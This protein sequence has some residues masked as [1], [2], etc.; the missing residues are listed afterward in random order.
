MKAQQFGD[1]YWT[2]RFAPYVLA[3]AVV[4][5]VT[6]LF[7]IRLPFSYFPVAVLSGTLV[8]FFHVLRWRTSREVFQL[9]AM[10]SGFVPLFVVISQLHGA[11]AFQYLAVFVLSYTAAVV[12]FRRQVFRGLNH[13]G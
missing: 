1:A 13:D 3:A 12:I 9:A 6:S 8:F 11:E 7:W 4:G 10:A 5:L 2:A